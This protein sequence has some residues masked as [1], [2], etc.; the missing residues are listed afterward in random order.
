MA[1]SKSLADSYNLRRRRFVER[2]RVRVRKL[3]P[4][5]MYA[6]WGSE[7]ALET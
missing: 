6:T 5:F 7:G 3:R 2:F 1:I 4:R